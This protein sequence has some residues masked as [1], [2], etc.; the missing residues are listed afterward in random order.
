M[1]CFLKLDFSFNVIPADLYSDIIFWV[2]EQRL[3][4]PSTQMQK[5]H[6]ILSRHYVAHLSCCHASYHCH[7][8]EKRLSNLFPAENRTQREWLSKG[9][10]W[11]SMGF[12]KPNSND[13]K[14]RWAEV[15]QIRTT[16]RTANK[17]VTGDIWK[18]KFKAQ[19]SINKGNEFSMY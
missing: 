10:V 2:R 13:R 7:R 15:W 16:R 1:S 5:L 17:P 19:V 11:S 14:G 8:R 4:L 18:T 9:L 12:R 3:R 6:I